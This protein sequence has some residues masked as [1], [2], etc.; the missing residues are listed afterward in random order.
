MATAVDS[1]ASAIQATVDVAIADFDF[2]GLGGATLQ[3]GPAV[4]RFHN[5]GQQPHHMVLYRTPRL[6]TPDDI[7]QL[8]SPSA[9]PT[10][11]PS[12]WMEAVWVGYTAILS[13]GREVFTLTPGS[14]PA[15][16]FV[17]DLKI[18]KPHLAE[19]WRKASRLRRAARRRAPLR[20]W[21]RR[22]G[23]RARPVAP[24]LRVSSRGQIRMRYEPKGR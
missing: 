24:R 23:S 22:P 6:I 7:R 18:Q 14:Y 11:P 10:P 9:P 17:S 21:R 12:W 15:P 19:G 16:R 13:P 20:L 5:V 3:A 8:L 2:R 4:W 1:G